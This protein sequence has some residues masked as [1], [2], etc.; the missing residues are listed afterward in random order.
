MMVCG[1]RV[2]RRVD[3]GG[4]GGGGYKCEVEVIS[5]YE[6]WW[7]KCVKEERKQV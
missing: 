1:I 4:N 5:R 2:G 3:V 7:K 6:G